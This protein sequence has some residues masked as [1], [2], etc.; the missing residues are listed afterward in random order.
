MRRMSEIENQSR[1]RAN[2][3]PPGPGSPESR[4]RGNASA[5]EGRIGC[6]MTR[7]TR[8][9]AAHAAGGRVRS[10]E[11]ATVPHAGT[12]PPVLSARSPTS[13]SLASSEGSSPYESRHPGH[14]RRRRDHQRRSTS[15]GRRTTNLR[16]FRRW[17][18]APGAVV[19]GHGNLNR[20]RRPQASPQPRRPRPQQEWLR[21]GRR[22]RGRLPDPGRLYGR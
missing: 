9:A 1:R 3:R 18:R 21:L 17:R 7:A 20:N 11:P 10:T 8:I 6:A 15:F 4:E 12:T 5:G 14:G 2:R 19:G 16:I 13:R 22:Q